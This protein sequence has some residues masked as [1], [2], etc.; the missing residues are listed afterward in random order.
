MNETEV[1]ILGIDVAAVEARLRELGADLVFDGEMHAIYLDRDDGLLG[2]RR[3]VLRL[4][5]EGERSVMTLKR[6]V[7]DEP[8][9]IREEMEVEI[10]DL[11]GMRR[12]LACLGFSEWLAVRKH[13]RSYRIGETHVEID[14]HMD[15]YAFIPEFIEIEAP[16]R[17]D[18]W[19]CAEALGFSRSDCR[20]WTFLDIV[21]HYGGNVSGP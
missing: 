12:I 16:R 19:R 10:S 8:V 21:R 4:R 18:I 6:F 11:E 5:R 20:P 2:R 1:K 15:D 13:R 7:S 14:R 17:E 3:D 9:K